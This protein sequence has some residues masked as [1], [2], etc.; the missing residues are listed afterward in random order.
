MLPIP[1]AGLL[2]PVADPLLCL[3]EGRGLSRDVLPIAVPGA[4]VRGE[5]VVSDVH[6]EGR[7]DVATACLQVVG[8]LDDRTLSLDRGV[9]HIHRLTLRSGR[10]GQARAHLARELLVAAD[11]AAR[12]RSDGLGW[13][14]RLRRDEERVTLPVDVADGQRHRRRLVV[15]LVGR[16]LRRLLRVPARGIPLGL[17]RLVQI[18]GVGWSR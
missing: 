10:L 16:R 9:A 1:D 2:G 17:G 18:D 13:A 12:A 14:C 6:G 4:V 5:M 7:L 3:G 15:H 11:V 8:E